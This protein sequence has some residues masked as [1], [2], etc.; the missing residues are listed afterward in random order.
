HLVDV[1]VVAEALLGDPRARH[2]LNRLAGGLG[3]DA[4]ALKRILPLLIAIH[5][6][7]KACPGFL[8]KSGLQAQRLPD[9][10]APRASK[11]RARYPHALE[12]ARSL[13]ELLSELGIFTPHLEGRR[14]RQFWHAVGLGVTAHHGRFFAQQDLETPPEIPALGPEA[15]DWPGQR[16]WVQ[17]RHWLVEQVRAV[18]CEGAAPVDCRPE[19][20]SAVAM[21]LNGFTILCDW[22]GSDTDYF[23][24]AG[25]PD[26]CE[27]VEKAR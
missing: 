21:L 18:L 16:E 13:A 14:Q 6:L 19:N 24:A 2:W 10:A 4:D 17:A 8:A 7:G 20:L 5:D 1:G 22:I 23:E 15:E 3:C 26:M 11:P 9:R 27:Y 25:Y 12:L